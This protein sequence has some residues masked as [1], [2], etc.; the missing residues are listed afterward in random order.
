LNDLKVGLVGAGHIAEESHLP[1]YQKNTNV[2]LTA[3]CDQRLPAATKLA[4]KF[5]A[6]KVYQDQTSML[7]KEKLDVVDICTPPATHK[8]LA[9]EAMNAGCHVICEKPMAMSIADTEEMIEA[10]KRN[11]VRLCIVHQNLC[12]A[13]VLKAKEI[14]DSGAIGDV[15][16]VNVHTFEMRN[17][18]AMRDKDHWSHRLPGGIFFEIIPHPVYLLLS[19]LK[20]GE[21]RDVLSKKIGDAAWVPKD[22]L[23]VLFENG[24][25][26]GEVSVTC[27]SFMH[28]DT[29]EIV[30]TKT[31]L[32]GDLWGRTVIVYKPHGLDAKSV[33]M[34]NIALSRQLFSV[35]G[36]T[37]STLVK[38]IRD[39]ITVSAHYTFISKFI[40]G[41]QNNSELPTSGED[42]RDTVKAVHTICSQI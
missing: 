4:G 2:E 25:A 5:G 40:E 34:S 41:I 19:F 28:G 13:A 33:G 7:S 3:I 39:P 18:D 32:S 36:S 35:V 27:N 6:Q 37:A 26:V 38:A 17:S 8:D 15:L 9:V 30:G 29:F 23:K 31:A 24:R 16:S 12:N 22:E 14:V 1:V 42:G 21:V 11:N 10:S 20:G